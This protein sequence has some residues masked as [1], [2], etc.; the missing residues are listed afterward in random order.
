MTHIMH[1]VHTMHTCTYHAYLYILYIPEII[2]KCVNDADTFAFHACIIYHIFTRQSS[3]TN[4]YWASET[5]TKQG[6]INLTQK[7]CTQ[8]ATKPKTNLPHW[9]VYKRTTHLFPTSLTAH[10]WFLLRSPRTDG[11][12]SPLNTTPG[13][14]RSTIITKHLVFITKSNNIYLC[15]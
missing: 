7:C 3:P 8:S 1:A 10:G 11:V 15:S 5:N 9:F 13:N 2:L 12:N 6:Y 14:I 4:C